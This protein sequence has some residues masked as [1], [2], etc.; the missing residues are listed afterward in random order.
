VETS[1]PQARESCLSGSAETVL[2]FY[3]ISSHRTPLSRTSSAPPAQLKKVSPSQPSSSV[4]A[5]VGSVLQSYS[6]LGKSSHAASLPNDESV[7]SVLKLYGA[8]DKSEPVVPNMAKD[9]LSMT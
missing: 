6:N 2:Q 3:A 9:V 1:G 4:D 5:S 8:P 7:A